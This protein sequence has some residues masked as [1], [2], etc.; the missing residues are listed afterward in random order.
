MPIPPPPPPPPGPPPPPTLNQ[1]NTDPP[2]LSRDE[3]RGRGA[4][5]QD[6]CKGAKLKKVAQVNDR[7]APIIEK[8]KGG[9]G[10]YSSGA[11]PLQPRGG[12]FQG[13]VPKLRPVGVK[14]NSDSPSGKQSLQV[15]GTR[16]VAPRPA[17]SSSSG[18]HQ[19]DAD[20]NRA[21]PP[22]LPRTQRPSLPDLSRPNSAS[23][24]GMKH[25]SS[26]PPPP[27]PGRRANAPPAPPSMH[28]NKVPSYNR[29]KPLPPTPGQRLPGNREGPPAPPP[30]KPPP[31]PVN[32]RTGPSS[33]GQSLAPPPPPYRQPPGVPNGPAS[34]TNEL[35]PEL[36]QRHNSLHRKT[37]GPTRG[38]APPPPPSASPSLQS[39]RPPPPA[40]DPPSR[41]AAPPPPPPP[42]IRNGG[43]DAPPPPPP[44]R[45]HGTSDT[46]SRGKPPP[47]PTRT[48]V[49]PPPPPPPMRNGHRDSISTVRSFLDD[50]ES[51]Y[52]FHPVEDFPAPEEFRHFQ[53]IYPSKTNRATRGAPP[54]P[55]IPR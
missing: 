19:D 49:G 54:L 38:M 17:V 51:K 5:L 3:Q 6:I 46:T 1:A 21:S 16:S 27:P 8:S 39:S 20:N 4:L 30:I 40:R 41:G 52:S 43:R 48:P 37:P 34:P 31:S 33:Q 47:P 11:S 24:A 42:M 26:A 50:F 35:A 10:G 25:S 22:E 7:S 55:P 45:M 12:L 36:P 44:Y 13:G 28:N 2:K 23:S 29:E 14:D 53:R 9:G 32:L 15:P 18:R